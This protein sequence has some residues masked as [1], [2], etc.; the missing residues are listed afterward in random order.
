MLPFNTI[1]YALQAALDAESKEAPKTEE[2]SPKPVT[3]KELAA[4]LRG[5]L[6]VYIGVM[7]KSRHFMTLHRIEA[8]IAGKKAIKRLAGEYGFTGILNA[9]IVPVKFRDT[10]SL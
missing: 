9:W 7:T 8:G 5:R 2:E 10:N 6:K 3:N 4:L 1:S